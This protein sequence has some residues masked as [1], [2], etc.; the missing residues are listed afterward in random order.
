MNA[1]IN[2]I[3]SAF[4]TMHEK[5]VSLSNVASITRSAIIKLGEA[6]KDILNRRC[7]VI[8]AIINT[9]VTLPMYVGDQGGDNVGGGYA[10]DHGEKGSA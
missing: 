6:L 5:R 9:A 10:S 8:E 1:I 2:S 4:V 7:L 3:K